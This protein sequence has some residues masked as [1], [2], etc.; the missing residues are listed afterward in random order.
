M[1]NTL[2]LGPDAYALC[3]ATISTSSASLSVTW[4]DGVSHEFSSSWLR[5]N[6][7]ETRNQYNRVQPRLWG[8]ELISYF[9]GHVLPTLPYQEVVKIAQGKPGSGWQASAH[10][11][12]QWITHLRDYGVALVEGVPTEPGTVMKMADLIAYHRKTHYGDSFQVISELKPQHLAY[13]PVEL[14]PHTDLNYKESSPGIQLL[15]CLSS[16][17]EGGESTF[18]DGFQVAETLRREKPEAFRTL[19]EVPIPF[20]VKVGEVGYQYHKIPTIC[21]DDAGQLVEIHFNERTRA[22]LELPATVVGPVYEALA[23]FQAIVHRPQLG[24]EVKMKAGDMVAFNNRRILHGRKAFDPRT[25]MRHLEGCYCD[26]DEFSTCLRKHGI[27]PLGGVSVRVG[28]AIE[29]GN[30]KEG[31]GGGKKRVSPG[32]RWSV[33]LTQERQQQQLPRAS[34]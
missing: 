21:V 2:Q 4:R 16:E 1:K 33:P 3:K 22:P 32:V 19:C 29:G 24:V 14:E 30:G 25:G 12:I 8:Q 10:G 26:M 18:V 13:T 28:G 9:P 20:V 23:E 17:A 5:T 7:Y 15:H 34:L 31:G 27:T 6:C 11:F